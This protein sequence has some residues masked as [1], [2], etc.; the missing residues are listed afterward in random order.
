MN[1]ERLAGDRRCWPCTI[2]NLGIGLVIAWVPIVVLLVGGNAGS[3]LAAAVW[4]VVVTTVVVVRVV[5]RGYLPFA[6]RVAK[7]IGLHERLRPDASASK[8]C[9]TDDGLE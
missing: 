2:A 7:V 8:S 6:D 3:I 9:G 5:G 4:G 1:P